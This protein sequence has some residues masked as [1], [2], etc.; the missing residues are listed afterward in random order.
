MRIQAERMNDTLCKTQ[1]N[2]KFYAIVYYGKLQGRTDT[3]EGIKTLD[4]LQKKKSLIQAS[5]IAQ[6]GKMLAYKFAHLNLICGPMTSKCAQ[7]HMYIHRHIYTTTTIIKQFWFYIYVLPTWM[8][9]YHLW[10][11][12]PQRPEG[13]IGFPG[14]GVTNSCHALCGYWD[15][16]LS[17]LQE[18]FMDLIVKPS[19][20]FHAVFLRFILTVIYNT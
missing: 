14:V 11:W 2:G 4:N 10:A 19:L 1:I 20:Q 5:G 7:L 17:S 18:Q 9:V 12:C 8:S 15:S 16:I 13:G 6:Q 3:Y